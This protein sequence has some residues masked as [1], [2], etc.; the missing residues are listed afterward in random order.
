M[1]NNQNVEHQVPDAEDV[2]VVGSRFS[3][4][5]ELKHTREAQEAVEAELWCVDAQDD[6]CQV[7]GE[8][9]DNVHFELKCMNVAVSEFR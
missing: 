3:P 9:G 8:D 7:R 5:K 6:V 2:W 1:D 4:I